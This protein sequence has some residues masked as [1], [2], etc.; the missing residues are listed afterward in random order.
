MKF[1]PND[2]IINHGD[3]DVTDIPL[4]YITKLIRE[5]SG[6]LIFK[7]KDGELRTRSPQYYSVVSKNDLDE[8]LKAANAKL[9]TLNQ[10]KDHYNVKVGDKYKFTR[11]GSSLY[12]AE[13]IIINVIIS[14]V[15]Y[16]A[17]IIT[18]HTKNV[19]SPWSEL[20][21]DINHVFGS[22]YHNLVKI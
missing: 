13:F 20:T 16:Y 17:A 6:L 14:G 19:G 3:Y 21:T 22:S 1:K 10:F 15:Y 12:G 5:E 4:G 11:Q 8:Y 18:V 2:L 9:E 7:D